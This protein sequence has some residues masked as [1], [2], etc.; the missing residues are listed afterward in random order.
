MATVSTVPLVT[1]LLAVRDG[2]EYVR[3][4]LDSALGQ[5]I[6]DVEVLVVDDASGDGTPEILAASATERLRVLRNALVIVLI[7]DDH[8]CPVVLL[9][10]DGVEEEAELVGS[11]HR[12]DDEVERR[13]HA[14]H[15]P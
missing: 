4:A 6:T 3:S 12:R 5:T 7:D 14:R 9:R 8:A 2:E 11:T 1:V 13:R 15:W 10:R